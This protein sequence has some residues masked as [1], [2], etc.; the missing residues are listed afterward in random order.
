M[1]KHV[2]KITTVETEEFLSIYNAERRV[3]DLTDG[4]EMKSKTARGKRI[5]TVELINMK[6]RK[7]A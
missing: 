7:A 2:V 3:H 1:T 5:T 6:D 4:V